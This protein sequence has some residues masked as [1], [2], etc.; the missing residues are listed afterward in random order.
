ME[1]LLQHAGSNTL[2]ATLLAASALACGWFCR[3]PALTHA[4]W[5]LVLVKLA[6]PGVAEIAIEVPWIVAAKPESET[7]PGEDS[8]ADAAAPAGFLDR[9]AATS[10]SAKLRRALLSPSGR[11]SEGEWLAVRLER[12]SKILFGE[13]SQRIAVGPVESPS[14]KQADLQQ[15]DLRHSESKA[16]SA[17]EASSS[18]MTNL[19]ASG[20]PSNQAAASFAARE[21]TPFAATPLLIGAWWAGTF[22]WFAWSAYRV[23]RFRRWMKHGWHAPREIQRLTESLADQMG[24]ASPPRVFLAAAPISPMVFWWGASPRLLFP[25]ELACRLERPSLESLLQ[26]ELAHLRRRDHWVRLIELLITG[27]FWWHPLVWI[28]RRQL[29][30]AEEECCDALGVAQSHSRRR[31]YALA[32]MSAIDFLAEWRPAFPPAACGLGAAGLLRRRL[33]AIMR[34]HAAGRLTNV[35]RLVV[36]AACC[37]LPFSLTLKPVA[38]PAS[39]TKALA[40]L[41]TVLHIESMRQ[42]LARKLVSPE[43]DLQADD[44]WETPV[45]DSSASLAGPRWSDVTLRDTSIVVHGKV[46]VV[47]RG[48]AEGTSIAVEQTATQSRLLELLEPRGV[49][50]L[51]ISPGGEWLVW[52]NGGDV[53]KFA[54]LR[55]KPSP[56]PFYIGEPAVDVALSADLSVLAIAHPQGEIT[57]WRPQTAERIDRLPSLGS[58]PSSLYLSASGGTV[59]A[60]VQRARDD[61]TAAVWRASSD[62][63]VLPV[64]ETAPRDVFVSLDGLRVAVA[65]SEG[66]CRLYDLGAAGS[67]IEAAAMRG[68]MRPTLSAVK[69]GSRR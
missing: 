65:D 56:A 19:G 14:D 46:V 43:S 64:Q 41:A 54:D 45:V 6:T 52:I 40:P 16:S 17:A 67:P 24:L 34:G 48:S 59:V 25:A 58:Q 3:R 30:I 62:A 53:V 36:G 31:T 29:H 4:L 38:A 68:K 15:R 33:Q 37:S 8:T 13:E 18:P 12:L 57:R 28:A 20:N 55:G 22:V 5:L 26:H 7:P 66:C 69:P 10:P 1:S 39:K 32:L 21:E 49:S 11:S 27:L 60:L 42:R 44:H 47:V 35:G 9:P 63:I 23:W 51:A 50:A 61:S 2:T